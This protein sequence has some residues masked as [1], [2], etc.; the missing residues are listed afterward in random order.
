MSP[1]L[2]HGIMISVRRCGLFLRV[3]T[4]NVA[5]SMVL[6][7]FNILVAPLMESGGYTAKIEDD[8]AVATMTVGDAEFS[9]SSVWLPPSC[10]SSCTKPSGW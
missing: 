10:T 9:F 7:L 3:F 4:L 2:K 5:L 1:F 6:F 8:D